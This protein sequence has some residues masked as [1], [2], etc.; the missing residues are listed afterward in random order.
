MEE[1]EQTLE[2]LQ[3]DTAA[4]DFYQQDHQVVTDKLAALQA[5]EQKIEELMERWVELEAMQED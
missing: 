3:E 4:A 5:Q 1:A 2:S